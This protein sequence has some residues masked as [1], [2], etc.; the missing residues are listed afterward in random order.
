MIGVPWITAVDLPV[1]EHVSEFLGHIVWL[2][3]A[4]QV[5]K[6]VRLAIAGVPD[7]DTRVSATHD[8]PEEELLAAATELYEQVRA[9]V[10]P[11]RNP[12][13]RTPR[14]VYQRRGTMTR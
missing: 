14:L 8:V 5:R 7:A 12:L 9:E 11:D 3:E 4:E 6:A 2:L 1:E 13:Q 10:R